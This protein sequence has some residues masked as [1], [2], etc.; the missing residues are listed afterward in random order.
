MN[1]VIRVFQPYSPSLPNLGNYFSKLWSRRPF[2]QEFSR[3]SRKI[4]HGDSVIGQLWV[5][6]GPLLMASVYYLLM[7]V[8]QGGHQGAD[9]FIHILAG[10]FS[11]NL[12]STA[13]RRGSTSVTSAGKLI[14]N[15]SFPRAILPITATSIAFSQYLYSLIVYFSLFVF[16]GQE[17]EVSMLLLPAAILILFV[18]S[19]GVALLTSTLQVY[20]RDTVAL[21]PYITRLWMYASPVL[22]YT[23]QIDEILGLSWI[24]FANPAFEIIHVISSVLTGSSDLDAVAW[25]TASVWAIGTLLL[26]FFVFLR[27]EGEFA[28]HL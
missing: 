23:E 12:I 25:V 26:G 1:K 6:L 13:A 21:L 10:V 18:F 3:S 17:F 22:Y 4:E 8:V 24:R 2:I 7:F 15:S 20:F 28:V 14:L 11:F 5:V 16:L 9:Y 27:R 19:L